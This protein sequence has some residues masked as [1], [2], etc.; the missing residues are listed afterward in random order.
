MI[1]LNEVKW[2]AVDILSVC[3]T[4]GLVASYVWHT[5]TGHGT[6]ML[7]TLFMVYQYAQQAGGVIGSMAGNFQSLARIRADY[8]SGQPIWQ[9]PQRPAGPA[10]A[11]AHW[12]TIE[13]NGLQHRPAGDDGAAADD[14][15]SSRGRL[16]DVSLRLSRGERIAIVGP[17]GSGKSTLMRALAGLYEPRAAQIAVDGV[18]QPG[19]R[20]LGAIATLIPQERR[21]VR[22]PACAT[23]SCSTPRPSPA[24]SSRRS[25]SVH[26]TKCWSRCVTGSTPS[27]AKAAPT[28]RAASA[29]GCAWRAACSWRATIRC[30]CSTNR[31]ARSTR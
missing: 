24:R 29:S 23:T 7:G 10:V 5:G 30:C 6:V 13:V 2:C 9:A 11:L 15:E 14:R 22:M 1:V 21:G 20:H 28:C 27:S 17:S 8:A 18:E 26:S 3:L 16:H 25:A 31:P 19:L 4:W 12:Q